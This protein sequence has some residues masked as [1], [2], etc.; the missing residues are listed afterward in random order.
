NLPRCPN[1]GDRR[2]TTVIPAFPLLPVLIHHSRY[3]S[4]TA[5]YGGIRRLRTT[6]RICGHLPAVFNAG[7]S[8]LKPDCAESHVCHERQ[9]KSIPLL[10]HQKQTAEDQSKTD[11][12]PSTADDRELH[13]GHP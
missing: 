7:V 12:Q 5:R 10:P 6:I 9:H 1:S 3:E 8:K 4:E 11:P 2:N 13:T